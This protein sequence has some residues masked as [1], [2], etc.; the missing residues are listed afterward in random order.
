MYISEVETAVV[1]Q[2]SISKTTFWARL[3]SN[4]AYPSS[5]W[6]RGITLSTN[7]LVMLAIIHYLD[8]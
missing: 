6:L 5:A 8:A 4:N 1:D 3:F 7:M 2:R